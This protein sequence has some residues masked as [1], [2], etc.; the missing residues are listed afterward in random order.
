MGARLIVYLDAPAAIAV[1][2]AQGDALCWG[3][4]T[5]VEV[6]APAPKIEAVLG[7]LWVVAHADPSLL[8]RFAIAPNPGQIAPEDVRRLE[9]RRTL[10]G[11]RPPSVRQT[12]EDETGQAAR[13]LEA[14]HELETIFSAAELRGRG[15]GLP[16]RRGASMITRMSIRLVPERFNF[17]IAM[18]PEKGPP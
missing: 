7:D 8:L 1:L 18:R 11:T 13:W 14:A 3:M 10:D 2:G 5:E 16:A 17:E 15:Q 9:A 4:V 12:L 6:E